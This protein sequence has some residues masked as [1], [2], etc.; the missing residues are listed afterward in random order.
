MAHR[1]YRPGRR[2]EAAEETRRRIVDATYALHAEQGVAATTMTHIAERAG[3]S[4]GS[5]YHHFPT[6]EDA[7]GACSRHSE[8]AVPLPTEAIFAGLSSTEKRI[9][10]LADAIFGY[11]ERLPGFER[12]RRDRDKY[13][14]LDAFFAKEERRRVDLAGK[15]LRAR[16]AGDLRPAMIAALLDIA[17]YHG[18]ARAGLST[19][20]AAERIADVINAWLSARSRSRRA[21]IGG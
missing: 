21:G 5:V 10:R 2:A 6:Y 15:A 16:G 13:P 19:G 7:I 20:A 14:P 12:V 8:E 3:V 18:L 9:R 1:T 11:Y 4:I 17:V